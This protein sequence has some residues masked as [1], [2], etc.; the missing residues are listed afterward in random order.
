VLVPISIFIETDCMLY[1]FWDT[2]RQRTA[3]PWYWG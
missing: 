3:W 2:Q 1:R